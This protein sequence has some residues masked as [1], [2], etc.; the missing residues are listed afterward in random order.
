[1]IASLLRFITSTG[2][3]VKVAASE[4]LPSLLDQ[5]TRPP[6]GYNT[7]FD[8][9]IGRASR[10][11]VFVLV[12]ALLVKG[13]DLIR[14]QLDVGG[15]LKEAFGLF[16]IAV[17]IALVYKPFAY[18]CG[19]RICPLEE[20]GAASLTLP[21]PLSIRQIAFSVLYTFIPWLP[22]LAFIRATVVLAHGALLDF[23]LIAPFICFLYMNFNF[24]KA[25]KVITNGRSLRVWLSLLLPLLIA[26]VY[27]I[28]RPI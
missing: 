2:K 3:F 23:L 16:I 8:D 7:Q 22:V 10:L 24:Y 6:F 5:P 11:I 18:I 27:I 28:W 12:I 19:V 14:G 4:W 25:I 15:T 13:G 17:I 26:F 9:E 20:A 1:L 21:Q